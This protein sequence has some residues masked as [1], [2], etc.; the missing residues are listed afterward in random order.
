TGNVFL[1]GGID[2]VMLATSGNSVTLSGVETITGG[3]GDDRVWIVGSAQGVTIDLKE[4]D[5]RLTLDNA[6]NTLTVSGAES[7]GGGA[8]NDVIKIDTNFTGTIS[9]G[10]G[11][12]SLTFQYGVTATLSG[13]ET[14]VSGSDTDSITLTTGYNGA[15][16][17][18][19]IGEDQV[20]FAG[21]GTATFTNV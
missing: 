9:L 6:M 18:L 7:I 13:V 11:S 20:I 14:V 3:G 2:T 10:S 1:G 17:D 15:E 4:G 16:I 5:D 8:R 12:D 21:S 19:G